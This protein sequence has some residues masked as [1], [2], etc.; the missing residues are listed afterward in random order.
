M[1]A[2]LLGE[3]FGRGLEGHVGAADGVG[4]PG[5]E[6]KAAGGSDADVSQA[7]L[8]ADVRAVVVDDEAVDRD[9]RGEIEGRR[10]S[11]WKSR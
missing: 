9:G 10:C 3:D 7:A 8:E 6:G 5:I 2:E 1:N 11:Q 4:R